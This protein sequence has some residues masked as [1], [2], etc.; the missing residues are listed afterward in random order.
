MKPRYEIPG[1]PLM[2]MPRLTLRIKIILILFLL[3][4]LISVSFTVI[5]YKNLKDDLKYELCGRLKNIARLGALTL[6]R[7]AYGRLV[8]K[9]APDQDVG[10]IS[11]EGEFL[12]DDDALL[13]MHDNKDYRTIAEQLIRVRDTEKDLILYV[14]TLTPTT[15]KGTA[16]FVVDADTLDDMEQEI[17][18]GKR[19]KDSSY[20]SQSY[21]I[22]EQ[23][24]TMTALAERK[25]IVDTEFRHDEE[26]GVNSVMGFAPIYGADGRYLGVLGADISDKN[27]SAVLSS[28][29][30]YYIIISVIA[31]FLSV[32]SSIFIGN[33]ITRPLQRLFT[34]LEALAS[35]DGDLTVQIPVRTDD[36]IGRV[37][38]AFNGF[39]SRLQAMVIEIKVILGKLS[40]FTHRLHEATSDVTDNI[41]SQTGLEEQFFTGSKELISRVSGI[42]SSAD[43][44]SEG[45]IALNNRL[46]A[47][48]GSIRTI[49]E[50]YRGVMDVT[51]SI[52]GKINAGEESLKTTGEIMVKINRSSGEMSS[53]MEIINDISDQINLLALNAAIE[54]ARA[55]EAGRGFAVVADEISK[56]ADKTTQNITE[57]DSLIK[58]NDAEIKN[59]I[60]SV[61]RTVSI[62]NSIITD[63]T[64]TSSMIETM[65]RSMQ[66]QV[67]V[68][69][70][71][72]RETDTMK[73]LM[74][75]INDTITEHTA[76]VK[77]LDRI[78]GDIQELSNKNSSSVLNMADGVRKIDEMSGSLSRVVDFF[79]TG[80]EK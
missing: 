34:S 24:V 66:E 62:I 47:L 45:F 16:R 58:A 35:V 5:S 61:N 51:R 33:L 27:A 40:S 55:G 3:S 54:S 7:E 80:M 17:R 23:P 79:K 19:V 49:M 73:A 41:R 60:V 46:R 31:V 67:A 72:H 11:G 9:M 74:E 56:L 8:R 2:K 77:T 70:T 44:Q 69:E 6:D 28:S 39:V 15:K 30:R 78:I 32:L 43:V 12:F 21:D 4:S 20:Y 37:S 50:E 59:G 38:S 52:T 22:S 10:S 68:D 76:A 42:Q 25:N 57:I 75:S 71:V 48:S 13:G 1:I 63:I 26:Y 53:I 29:L 36:E 14:Y 65:F 18:T 64:S